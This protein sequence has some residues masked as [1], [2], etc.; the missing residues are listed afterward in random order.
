MNNARNYLIHLLLLCFIQIVV[1]DNIH[2][3]S[4]VHVNIYIMALFLLPYRMKGISLLLYALGLGLLMDLMDNTTGIHAAAS[5]LVAYVRPRLLQLT[6]GREA[7]DEARGFI[8]QADFAWFFKYAFFSILLFNTVLIFAE[9]F[10]FS[11][12]FIS[13]LRILFST[14]ISL[15]CV[16]LYYFIGFRKVKE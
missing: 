8:R 5:T 1:L 11:N 2:L 4:Y 16:V 12:L 15:L 7:M 14:L 3:G 6:S 13:C 9:A 10:T